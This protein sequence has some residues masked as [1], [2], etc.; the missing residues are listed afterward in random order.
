MQADL[1][2]DVFPHQ[3]LKLEGRE[4]EDLKKSFRSLLELS[5]KWRIPAMQMTFMIKVLNLDDCKVLEEK[6]TV[7]KVI[8]DVIVE[9]IQVA[10][11]EK[12]LF[13][14]DYRQFLLQDKEESKPKSRRSVALQL[15]RSLIAKG[16]PR[17][18]ELSRTEVYKLVAK[19][20]RD[21]DWSSRGWRV[22]EGGYRL[23]S[24]LAEL[25]ALDVY[26][27]ATEHINPILLL[28]DK[29]LL[30]IIKAA[31]LRCL[32]AAARHD[33]ISSSWSGNYLLSMLEM[34]IGA[35]SN[36]VHSYA[37]ICLS[38]LLVKEHSLFGTCDISTVAVTLLNTLDFQDSKDNEHL[39]TCLF[40]I[41]KVADDI[42]GDT[43][44]RCFPKL[45]KEIC[46]RHQNKL[47][48]DQVSKSF[49]LLLHRLWEENT[50]FLK[51]ALCE[52]VHGHLLKELVWLSKESLVHDN[53][54]GFF[55]L[56]SMVLELEYDK[57]KPYM[58]DLWAH[59]LRL[60]VND[61]IDEFHLSFVL[62]M[63]VFLE[64]HGG[65]R[66]METLNSS[67]LKMFFDTLKRVWLPKVMTVTGVKEVSLITVALTRLLCHTEVFAGDQE[68]ETLWGQLLQ[69]LLTVASD[70]HNDILDAPE[71]PLFV[72]ATSSYEVASSDKHH[73]RFF[74]IMEESLDDT[75][76]AYL[77]QLW[78]LYER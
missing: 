64:K 8:K 22:K 30:P 67:S 50:G 33:R 49:T 47:F 19:T 59:L 27:F 24:V 13:R 40:H 28:A 44:K 9:N 32:Y 51:M 6:G 53:N 1:P 77:I 70:N 31:G 7:R 43:A 25:D 36:V 75:S 37:A 18:I 34:N 57:I 63:S 15:F 16:S 41:I 20:P 68:A 11:E 61:E 78:T 23:A 2:R 69:N 3:Q 35:A 38:V 52:A 17:V 74:Q 66:L 5:I 48:Y 72:I 42:S 76:Q 14:K 65:N 71:K 54:L 58:P 56:E 10:A 21:W 39:M 12:E 55:L 45:L 73:G 62:L 46:A 26:S 29:N 4:S 60:M